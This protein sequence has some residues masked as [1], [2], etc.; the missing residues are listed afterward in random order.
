MVIS[1]EG[2]DPRTT[3]VWRKFVMFRG[4]LWGLFAFLT[5]RLA[6]SAVRTFSD[7]PFWVTQ[8]VNDLSVVLLMVLAGF[9][10]R[11]RKET[12]N[13]YMMVG[14]EENGPRQ[15]PR[16]QVVAFSADGEE[17]QRLASWREGMTLPPQPVFTD[18]AREMEE[19]QE[20]VQPPKE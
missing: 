16:D 6:V 20:K 17:D 10:F 18:E 1:E 15:L 12:S 11:L 19:I 2:I 4:I 3:H 13:G 5:V 8:L 7:T 9:L 14:D